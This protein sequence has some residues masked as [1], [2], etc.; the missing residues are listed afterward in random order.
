MDVI[1]IRLE[2]V[3]WIRLALD[4][5]RFRTLAKRTMKIRDI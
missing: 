2:D 1:K 5:D 4:K 3:D